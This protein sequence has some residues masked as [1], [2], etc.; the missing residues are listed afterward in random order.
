MTEKEKQVAG[1]KLFLLRLEKHLS[2][3]EASTTVGIPRKE[4]FATLT[5]FLNAP[6]HIQ[7]AILSKGIS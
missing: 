2:A 4:Y 1:G 7:A 3:D 6:W 5:A